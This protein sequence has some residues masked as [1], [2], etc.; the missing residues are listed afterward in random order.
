MIRVLS[1]ID[2]LKS[3][4]NAQGFAP[5]I[6]GCQLIMV[7]ECLQLKKPEKVGKV[8]EFKNVKVVPVDDVLSS[9]SG[10]PGSFYPCISGNRHS[11]P[12][13]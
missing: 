11:F 8:D 10:K 3:K 5:E 2:V 13:Q 4:S 6:P 9:K 1:D 12:V 7:C